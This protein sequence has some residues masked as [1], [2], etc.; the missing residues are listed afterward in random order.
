MW[1][2]GT[3][4][5]IKE[6]EEWVDIAGIK[7]IAPPGIT[8]DTADATV[9]YN[10]ENEE[11]F[12]EKQPTLHRLGESTVIL[13]FEPDD[14]NQKSLLEKQI[15]RKKLD[16]RIL[17]P[18]EENYMQFA[19]YLTGFELGDIN[20]EGLLEATATFS[21]SAKPTFDKEENGDG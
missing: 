14:D 19:A 9:L 21:A 15:K 5:Q 16:C 12:E 20:P 17:F 2:I 11:G 18:D 10:E 13:L 4:F 7:N 6:S 1:G 8:T 3:R